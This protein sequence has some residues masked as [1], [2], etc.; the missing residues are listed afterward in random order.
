MRA[1]HEGDDAMMIRIDDGCRSFPAADE[2]RQLRS[3]TF[4]G[5]RLHC[6]RNA[7]RIA[8]S[9]QELSSTRGRVEIHS[10]KRSRAVPERDTARSTR[11][12]D[13][14]DAAPGDL[15]PERLRRTRIAS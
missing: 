5:S 4:S 9:R 8:A 15:D 3:A 14:L 10:A 2:V 12:H 1:L 11:A 6:A 7:S 13:P